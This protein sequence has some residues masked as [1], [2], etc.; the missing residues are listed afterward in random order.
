MIRK[1][2]LFIF[3]AITLLITTDGFTQLG[4]CEDSPCYEICNGDCSNFT[5]PDCADC[6]EGTQVPL[7]GGL[8]WLLLAGAGY[9]IKK[10][11][12]QRKKKD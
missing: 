1:K 9:G 4:P 8:L 7:D 5:D 2:I 6:L 3:L 10:I 12:G 11:V